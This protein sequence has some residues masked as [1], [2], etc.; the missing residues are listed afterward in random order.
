MAPCCVQ[1]YALTS[2]ASWWVSLM[3]LPFN[4]AATNE[5]VNESPNLFKTVEFVG[6]F[7]I[8]LTL[9]LKLIDFDA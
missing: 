7:L 9:V 4:S 5:P 8:A 1:T 3:R 2:T 6:T